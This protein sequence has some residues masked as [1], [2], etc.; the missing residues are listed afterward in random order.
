VSAALDPRLDEGFAGQ[1]P[2]VLAEAGR[3]VRCREVVAVM[4]QDPAVARH[5]ERVG[6]G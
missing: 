5:G 6:T 4:G 1:L 3:P 2:A